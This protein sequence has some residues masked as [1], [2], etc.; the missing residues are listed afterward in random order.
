[1]RQAL[2]TLL[3]MQHRMNRRV[4]PQWIT[5]DFAWHRAI[6]IECA[7]LVD[8]HGYKWW[9]QQEPDMAQVQLEVVDVWH[10]G[11]SARFRPALELPQLAAELEV[12]LAAGAAA[13]PLPLLDAAERLA[14]IAAGERRFCAAA[15][16][17]LLRAAGLDMDALYRQYLGKNVLNFFRQDHGYRE[18][19]YRKDWGGREDNTHLLELLTAI[20]V[21]APDAEQ[22]LYAALAERFAASA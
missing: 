1:M 8:H 17:Q 16:Q 9:K 3:R 14:A 13:A 11:M 15:F 19:T 6:W 22:R 21:A 18:G 10:F 2:T 7:E 12:E 4:H 20:D 5:R